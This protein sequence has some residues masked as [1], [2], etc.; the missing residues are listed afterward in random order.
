MQ[1]DTFNDY[2]ENWRP[3][4]L[5]T[6]SE[7]YNPFMVALRE[8]LGDCKIRGSYFTAGKPL[9]NEQQHPIDFSP[10]KDDML[11]K[12]LMKAI[13]VAVYSLRHIKN[14]NK[15]NVLLNRT[16]AQ[17]CSNYGIILKYRIPLMLESKDRDNGIFPFLFTTK[18]EQS[19]GDGRAGYF[20]WQI[21]EKDGDASSFKY[22]QLAEIKS[23]DTDEKLDLSDESII[24][25][26]NGMTT[27]KIASNSN[28]CNNNASVPVSST[29]LASTSTTASSL[30]A[31]YNAEPENT[32]KIII[33][34]GVVIGVLFIIV[35][36]VIYMLWKRGE[37][38]VAAVQT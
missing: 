35:F 25:Y 5:H 32:I 18:D 26:S 8:L 16:V 22:V 12:L 17:V 38:L 11:A 2:L 21:R 30:N 29:S 20:L 4:P 37:C 36:A 27:T 3:Q 15:Y 31:V 19:Y 10:V 23:I 33:I 34:L 24:F 28:L 6:N 9:C 14:D 13:S 7:G 1:S